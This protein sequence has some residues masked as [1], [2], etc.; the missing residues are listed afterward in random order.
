LTLRVVNA[1]PAGVNA[2]EML[3][4]RLALWKTSGGQRLGLTSETVKPDS[5]T[6]Q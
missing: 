2:V 1:A 3:Q 6:K 4:R 5:A